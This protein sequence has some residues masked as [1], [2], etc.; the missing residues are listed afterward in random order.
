ME[1]ANPQ[2]QEE[3]LLAQI[4]IPFVDFLG[5]LLV[6]N[7]FANAGDTSLIPPLGGFHMPQGNWAGA[8]QLLSLQALKPTHH[9]EKAA[10]PQQQR[11]SAAKT[12]L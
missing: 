6:K 1:F 8:P 4:K 7:P 2:V 12:H 11:H 9:H 10:S 3:I 5:G